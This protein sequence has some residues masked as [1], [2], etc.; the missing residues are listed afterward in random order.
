ML[1]HAFRSEHQPPSVVVNPTAVVFQL[2]PSSVPRRPKETNAT[3]PTTSLPDKPASRTASGSSKN[4][5]PISVYVKESPDDDDVKSIA[6][7][8][9]LMLQWTAHPAA[10][11]VM[12]VL[13]INFAYMVR[14]RAVPPTFP[15]HFCLLV[16]SFFFSLL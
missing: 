7:V 12:G 1:L 11:V 13:I 6:D 8:T 5:D 9:K 2:Q 4:N 14:F 3:P 10:V 16:L 15:C